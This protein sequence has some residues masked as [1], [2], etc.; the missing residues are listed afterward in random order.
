MISSR[1][2]HE[3]SR[4]K[5]GGDDLEGL[6][7]LSKYRSS[8]IGSTSVICKQYATIEFAPLPQPTKKNPRLCEYRMISQVIRKYAVKSI[9]SMMASSFSTLVRAMLLCE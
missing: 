6:R 4:S 1:S 9:W 3:K 5:S 2:F 7:N 8:S